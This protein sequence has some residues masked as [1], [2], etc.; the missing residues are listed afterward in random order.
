[1]HV[2]KRVDSNP[3]PDASDHSKID[4][5]GCLVIKRYQNSN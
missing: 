1:M 5:L 2:D 3:P 4:I